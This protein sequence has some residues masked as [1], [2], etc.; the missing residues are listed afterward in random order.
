MYRYETPGDA[1]I[2]VN[3]INFHECIKYYGKS[4]GKVIDSMLKKFGVFKVKILAEITVVN[5][6]QE[7]ILIEKKLVY[8]IDSKKNQK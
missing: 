3:F 8:Y 4:V 5:D 7:T 1:Y 6:K 2:D